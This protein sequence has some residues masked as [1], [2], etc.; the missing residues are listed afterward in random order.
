MSSTTTEPMSNQL[1]ERILGN[2]GTSTDDLSERI[3]E[4]AIRQIEDFGIRRFTVDDLA[5]RL[6]ISRMTIYR[7]FAKKSDLL[8]AALLYELRRILGEIDARVEQGET[9]EERLVEGFVA[10]LFILRDHRLLNRML[11]TEPELILPV[12]TVGAA[13]ALVASCEFIAGFARREAEHG[14]VVFDEGQLKA[15]SEMLAR[16]VLS[17]VLTPQSVVSLETPEDGR[18]FARRYLV[19]VLRMLSDSGAK[20]GAA[21]GNGAK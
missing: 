9:L 4:G 14:D 11:H 6:G 5:R 10:V 7:R 12:L 13:P 16:L 20:Q 15:A 8:Q 3:L 17:F 2:E 1:L 18:R 19:P 21:G